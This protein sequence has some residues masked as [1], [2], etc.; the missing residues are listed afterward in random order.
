MR[1]PRF[2]TLVPASLVLVPGAFAQ[3]VHELAVAHRA[4]QTFVTWRE[5]PA[6]GVHYRLYRSLAPIDE[7]A[8]LVDA[9]FL[10]EVDDQT[11]R[12]PER[13]AVER[14]ERTWVLTSGAVP[15]A[16]DQGVFVH[17]LEADG[18]GYYAVTSV[19]GEFEDTAILPGEN[20]SLFALPEFTAPPEPVLQA[21]TLSRELYGH[22]VG[23]R[24]T[25]YQ[26]ALALTPSRAFVFALEPGR[27]LGRHGL[28]LR[29]HPVGG[30]Y[31]QGW[32]LRGLVP[33]DVD[34]L[35]LS[36]L[37]PTSGFTFW[38]GAHER[39][40]ALP[41]ADTRV[42]NFTQERILW[43]LD[44][45]SAHLGARHDPERV[46][47]AGSSLG[48]TGGMYLVT[49]APERFSAA[50]F[51]NG[52]YDLLAGDYT[53]SSPYQSLFGSFALDLPTRAGIPILTRTNARRASE[54]TPE[55]DW[56]VLRLLNGRRDTK[57]GW[58]SFAALVPA[59]AQHHRPAAAYFD[60]RTHSPNGSWSPLELAL[61][62]RTTLVRRDRPTLCFSDSTLDDP[63]GNG[64]RTSGALVGCVGGRMDYDP[65][66]AATTADCVRFD[67]FLRA[68][69]A[70][71]DATVALAFAR[72]T[73]RRTAPFSL[74]PLE[75]V[76][77]VLSEGGVVLEEQLLT[78]D[79]H[80]Q[81][82]TP[83]V[84]VTTSPREARFERAPAVMGR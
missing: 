44:W 29:L 10:G 31:A 22:W 47:L 41:L 32:P 62:R 70:L 4:G 78:A 69:G 7:P 27:A 51:R 40:P 1:C 26:P 39:F 2:L 19:Q 50:L 60:N 52:N 71:D 46:A 53:D 67:V 18:F 79:E 37:H 57:V 49:E 58:A 80:G 48:A 56:P 34:I 54:A 28:L 5:S 6:V 12:N 66:T 45:V 36:D 21:R 59:L 74:A 14:A 55:E 38:F 35:A 43:T 13:S 15:L 42:W 23:D 8:D 77:F 9:D 17:T 83:L 3:E 75:T 25:P 30:T 64:S 65:L 33:S 73:P 63:I 82:H 24:D 81:V 11:S 84:P 68:E 72:L 20:A 61:V 76:H 16:V